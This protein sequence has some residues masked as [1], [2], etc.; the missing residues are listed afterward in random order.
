M[1]TL[2]ERFERLI[3]GRQSDDPLEISNRSIGQ[4]VALAFLIALPFLL[5]V[6]VTVLV[7]PG[8]PP[9]IEHDVLTPAEIA[10]RMLPGIDKTKVET[11]RDIEVLDAH[12]ELKGAAMA[13][14]AVRNNTDHT[15]TGAEV[16]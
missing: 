12:V 11:N 10:E 1:A 2:R 3:A 16:T 8:K 5:V 6:A 4:K 13:V 7:M 15:I 14:G 9:T